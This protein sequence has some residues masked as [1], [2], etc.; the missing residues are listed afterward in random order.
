MR[1]DKS[2][3]IEEFKA[4]INNLI[5]TNLKQAEWIC[6]EVERLT[7]EHPELKEKFTEWC[8]MPESE[9]RELEEFFTQILA[10]ARKDMKFERR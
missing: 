8:K 9:R 3:N 1:N 4:L 6:S 7:H 10:Q 5:P 2:V